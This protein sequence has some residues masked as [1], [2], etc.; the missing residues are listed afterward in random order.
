MFVSE[1]HPLV[2]RA[3]RPASTTRLRLVESRECRRHG[4]TEFAQYADGAGGLRWR[5]KRCIGEAVT[6]RHQKLRRVLVEEAGGACALCGYSRCIVSLHF[7]HVDPATKLF[8]MTISSGKSLAT[9]RE[10]AKKCVL[11]CSN[12]H[13]E[14]EAG[15]V[16]SPRAGA[17]FDPPKPLT[18][19][20]P[21]PGQITPFGVTAARG[22]QEANRR[23]GIPAPGR[24][25]SATPRL[26]G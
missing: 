15:V 20:L 6:R 11:L 9:Y 16:V 5:C 7:H 26:T 19:P 14:V 12:C 1:H 25:Q 23:Q 24:G 21:N 18:H 22:R 4:V 8:P 13:G 17:R 2:N 3:G 10:E